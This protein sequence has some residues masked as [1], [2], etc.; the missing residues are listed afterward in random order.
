MYYTVHAHVIIQH[1]SESGIIV[2]LKNNHENLLN[3]VDLVILSFPLDTYLVK[4]GI[5]THTRR[6]LN[7]SNLWNCLIKG[8]AF[9]NNNYVT[10]LSQHF[11]LPAAPEMVKFP[12]AIVRATSKQPNAS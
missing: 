11:Y 1:V 7:N 12:V 3:L 10:P 5:M 9:N 6:L 2:L 8:S 4:H